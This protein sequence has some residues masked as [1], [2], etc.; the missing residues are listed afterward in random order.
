MRIGFIF[1]FAISVS[2]VFLFLGRYSRSAIESSNAT[3]AR[4]IHLR[5]SISVD[6]SCNLSFDSDGELSV[7]HCDDGKVYSFRRMY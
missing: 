7:Y 5:D 6:P 4:L 1:A 2:F 3:R